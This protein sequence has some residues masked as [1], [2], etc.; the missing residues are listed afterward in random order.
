MPTIPSTNTNLPTIMIAERIASWLAADGDQPSTARPRR[1]PETSKATGHRREMPRP[2][3][4][5]LIGSIRAPPEAHAV[6]LL[7]HL[8]RVERG[9]VCVCCRVRGRADCCFGLGDTPLIREA[10]FG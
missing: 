10:V 7:H 1:H 5:A 3:P 8:N 6:G 4:L 2:G 9:T